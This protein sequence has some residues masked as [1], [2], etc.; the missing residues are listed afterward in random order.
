MKAVF[1]QNWSVKAQT[2]IMLGCCAMGI[3]CGELLRMISAPTEA[4]VL[5][6]ALAVV[7]TSTLTSS[8]IYGIIASLISMF[9]YNFFVLEPNFGLS[10]FSY[11]NLITFALMMFLSV[12]I[13]FVASRT[14][15]AELEARKK[16][17]ES[18]ILYHLTRD[19][20]KAQTVQ[21]A[22][23]L[24]LHNISHVFS[25]DCRMVLFDRDGNP[26]KNFI[27]YSNGQ[28]L[29]DQQ[30]SRNRTFEE[31]K[32][33]PADGY[34][35]NEQQYEWPAGYAD[36][37]PIASLAIPVDSCEE[38]S[39]SDYRMISTMAETAGLVISKLQVIINSERSK[40]EASQERYRSNLLR[41]ISHDLRTPLAGISGTAEVLMNELEEGSEPWKLARTMRK[42]TTWLFDLVQNILSLTRLQ[43]GKLK[44]KKQLEVVED[45]INAAVETM[46]IRVPEKKIIKHLPEEVLVAPMDCALIKQVLINLLDNGNKYSPHDTPLEI[47]LTDNPAKNCV[48]ISVMDCG[49]GLPKEALNKIF[50]LFYT[51]TASAPDSL[52]GFGLGLPICDTAMKAHK[53]SIEAGNRT[54]RSGAVFTLHIPKE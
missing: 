38:M 44:I 30:T 45:V 5:V 7:A 51:T 43:D 3:V 41:S 37:H 21:Q 53:G 46:S 19:L 1:S 12:L 34:Y 20:A 25:T 11:M 48:D 39:A 24:T 17:E 13:C 50:E 9:A 6:Y 49:E 26:E 28:M 27:L 15:Q 22:V 31:Y 40:Q 4:V 33:P 52:R 35:V 32:T 42:E 10:N 47:V 54:D 18:S 14:K 16:Q 23:E 36:G 2:L 29:M 8:Y